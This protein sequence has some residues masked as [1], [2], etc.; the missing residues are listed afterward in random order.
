MRR[1]SWRIILSIL[2]AIAVGVQ[3]IWFI[4]MMELDMQ[5][6]TPVIII[7]LLFP[8]AMGWM[9]PIGFWWLWKDEIQNEPAQEEA[10]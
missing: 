2:A 8:G 3:I 6:S 7:L 1:R 9:L 4:I 10:G 5:L